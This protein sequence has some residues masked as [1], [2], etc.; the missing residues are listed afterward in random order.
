MERVSLAFVGC[1]VISVLHLKAV[2]ANN[3]KIYVSALIDPDPSKS[4]YVLSLCTAFAPSTTASPNP[5]PLIFASL[6]EAL[7][8]N[9]KAQQ[10]TGIFYTMDAIN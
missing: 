2:Q 10:Q 7:E 9:S 6:D 5:T 4:S 1:G 3:D 8:V